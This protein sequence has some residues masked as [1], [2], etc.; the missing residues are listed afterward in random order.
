MNDWI[1]PQGAM[2][3]VFDDPAGTG[4]ASDFG[5]AVLW[6]RNTST[7]TRHLCAD[8]VEA[9]LQPRRPSATEQTAAEPGWP[10]TAWDTG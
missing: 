5:F 8:L 9:K 3:M 4:S 2:D 7:G 10:I 1:D 6:S